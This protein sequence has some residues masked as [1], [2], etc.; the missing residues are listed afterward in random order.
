MREQVLGFSMLTGPALLVTWVLVAAGLLG[1]VALGARAA[2]T[3]ATAGQA[4]RTP[5][6]RQARRSRSFRSAY[7]T[8]DFG[9]AQVRIWWARRLPA[10]VVLAAL[11]TALGG[12]L[13]EKVIRPFPDPLPITVYVWIAVGLLALGLCVGIAVRGTRARRPLLVVGA[14][15]SAIAVVLGGAGQVNLYYAEFPTLG[16]LAGV[17]GYRTVSAQEALAPAR[18]LVGA[19]RPAGTPLEDVWTAPAGMPTRGAMVEVPIP[20]ATSNFE[21]RPAQIYLPPA[22]FS[23]PRPELPVLVLLAGQPG[24]PSDWVMSGRLPLIADAFAAQHEGLA[25]VVVVA[26]P[27]GSP[28]GNTL[29]VDSVHGNA[30]TYLSV[31]VPAWIRENLQVSAAPGSM[32]IGGLSFGGTCALQLA[33]GAPTVYPTFL[34]LSGQGEPDVGTHEDTVATFFGGDE[35][36]F[37]LHN[38]ADILAGRR[39]PDLAGAFLYG[40]SDST[41][42]PASTAMYVAARNAGI[43]AHLTELP[44][45]HSYAVW[46]AGLEHELPWL[47]SRLELTR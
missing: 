26:D 1:L 15:V 36:A 9:S 8:R 38:P 7:A 31:D 6:F 39:F 43:D 25:P 21:A 24:E 42:G 20:G 32:A 35:N 19:D 29:C 13:V 2:R 22:Y 11:A 14:L 16:T 30:F 46:S 3:T 40:A 41:F 27:I 5:A 18:T 4:A 45:G 12:L 47:A 33:L 28:F 34:D 10:S 23:D 17:D 44:G 37:R